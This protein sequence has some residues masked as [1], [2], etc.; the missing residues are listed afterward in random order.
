MPIFNVQLTHPLMLAF[1]RLEELARS[2]LGGHGA[3]CANDG[4]QEKDH[5]ETDHYSFSA[6]RI[7]ALRARG[8]AAISRADGLI[9]LPTRRSFGFGS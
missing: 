7:T 3:Q 1:Q 4:D 9:A 6:T 5:V 8:L 2:V